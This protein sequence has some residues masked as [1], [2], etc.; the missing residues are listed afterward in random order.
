M[1]TQNCRPEAGGQG[2]VVA[3]DPL[4]APPT[5]ENTTAAATTTTARTGLSVRTYPFSSPPA[6]PATADSPG[7]RRTSRV[8]CQRRRP[9]DSLYVPG[10]AQTPTVFRRRPQG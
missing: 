5:S 9:P 4:P 7:D 6:K 1:V 3:P 8:S 2:S 10:P